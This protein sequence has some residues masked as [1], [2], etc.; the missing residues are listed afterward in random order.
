MVT[1]HG[2][3]CQTGPLGS[4]LDRF[5]SDFGVKMIKNMKSLVHFGF[6]Q[7]PLIF[8]VPELKKNHHLVG[9]HGWVGYYLW[10]QLENTWWKRIKVDPDE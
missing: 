5:F 6:L 3:F 10:G 8:D 9:H 1:M 2:I 7:V 4:G